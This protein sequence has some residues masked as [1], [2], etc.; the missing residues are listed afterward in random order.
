VG[1]EDQ[2]DSVE[3]RTDAESERAG[4]DGDDA[5]VLPDEV[6]YPDRPDGPVSALPPRLENWRRRSATGAMLTGFAF[7]LREVLEPKRNEPAI[8]LET[9]GVPP[10][11]LAV[12]A[13][14]DNVPPRQS[15]VRIRRWLLPERQRGGTA[16]GDDGT[17]DG[18]PGDDPYDA[19]TGPD[20]VPTA[21]P[22]RSRRPAP[23]PG[24]PRRAKKSRR[25]R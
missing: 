10:K 7:G 4:D 23:R 8:M 14:L 13:D 19:V 6:P 1:D 17:G 18:T 12:E 15:V 3:D 16:G 25:R 21:I 20:A 2:T 24:V 22:A 9:S 5:H 11:D